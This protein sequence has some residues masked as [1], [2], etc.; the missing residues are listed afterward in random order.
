MPVSYMEFFVSI[1]CSKIYCLQD[2][3]TCVMHLWFRCV[4]EI[5]KLVSC[6]EQVA[7]FLFHQEGM[8]VMVE[9]DVHDMFARLPGYG[10]VQT[11]Y[12]HDTRCVLVMPIEV[13]CA[14]ILEQFSQSFIAS[15][16]KLTVDCFWNICFM[17]ICG[18]VILVKSLCLR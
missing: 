14:V 15:R 5:E 6:L 13:C 17:F 2:I 4:C 18:I 11:F 12:N 1:W 16:F 8:N 9:P 3:P 10:F 7:S